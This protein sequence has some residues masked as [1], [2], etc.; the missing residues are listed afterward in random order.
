[1]VEA[2][3]VLRHELNKGMA[4]TVAAE[5]PSAA[6]IAASRWLPDAELRIYSEEYGRTGFQGGLNGYRGNPASADLQLFSGPRFGTE[7]RS[8]PGAVLRYGIH[9]GILQIWATLE[10]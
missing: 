5:M 6:E 4:E 7:Q 2:T 1:M 3:A 10:K 9:A 8:A